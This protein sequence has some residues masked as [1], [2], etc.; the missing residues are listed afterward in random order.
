MG[1]RPAATGNEWVNEAGQVVAFTPDNER[2]RAVLVHMA[3][4][5]GVIRGVPGGPFR[6]LGWPDAWRGAGQ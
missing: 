1:L 5:D 4:A 6:L 3:D 2:G